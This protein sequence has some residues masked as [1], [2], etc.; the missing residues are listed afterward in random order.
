MSISQVMIAG[1]NSGRPPNSATW[2]GINFD[3]IQEGQQ[4]TATVTFSNWDGSTAWWSLYDAGGNR[5]DSRVVSGQAYGSI[6]PSNGFN[7][8]LAFNFTFTA[9]ATTEGP[10]TYYVRIGST[11]GNNDYTQGGAFTLRDSSQ[12]PALVLDVDPASLGTMYG[13]TGWA[14]SS[15]QG[16]NISISNGSTSTNNGGTLIFN[17]TS[18]YAGDI[19]NANLSSSV[20]GTISLSAWINPTAVTGAT[21][22]IIAKELCYKLEIT[23]NGGIAW[24]TGKGYAP[25]EITAGGAADAVTA[26][27]WAQV[28]ATVDADHTRIYINGVEV[29]ETSGNI[30]GANN[31]A[32][33]IG[34]Y[35]ST[36]DLFAGSMGEIKVWNYALTGS[37]VTTQYNNSKARY[38]L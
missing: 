13:L 7:G 30:I 20:Y 32:F 4:Q 22:A 34:A 10:L 25:W 6:A 8:N 11:N 12:T 23:T 36:N 21:Q 37:D 35:D 16:N 31:H 1:S 5:L 26:G 18:T 17:G 27:A 24:M 29:A 38:G 2:Y 19:M 33:N 15:G 28:I 9:D 3:P 14:D